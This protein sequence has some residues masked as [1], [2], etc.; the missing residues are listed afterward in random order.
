MNKDFR[1]ATDFFSHRKTVR[2]QRTLKEKG[3]V[4]LLRLWA[5]VAVNNSKGD[6]AD[7]TD[8]D[9]EAITNYPDGAKL[10]KVLLETGFLN[11]QDGITSIHN[12]SKHNGFAYYAEERSEIAR[13]NCS[14]RWNK[15]HTGSILSECRESTP[16]PLPSPNQSP[17]PIPELITAPSP[18]P[19]PAPS[20][21][22]V[23]DSE[24]SF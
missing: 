17:A 15:Q 3:L 14:K 13:L 5:Y 24:I 1:I 2:L 19:G 6:I 10:R 11:E 21:E 8:K 7:L 23:P 22:P 20:P 18:E 9:L 16:N 12:W 4:A